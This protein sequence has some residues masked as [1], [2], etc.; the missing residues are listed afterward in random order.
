MKKML[1][2]TLVFVLAISCCFAVA[3]TATAETMGMAVHTVVAKAEN[4][5]TDDGKTTD[6]KYSLETAVCAVVL[7]DE[8]KIT[9]IRF[10]LTISDLGVNA[11]GAVLTEAGTEMKSKMDLKEAYGMGQYAPAG[12]WY[13]QVQALERYC[14]GKTVAEVLST[15][16]TASGVLDVEDLKTSCT[17]GVN[18]LLKA[19]ELAAANAR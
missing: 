17:I 1:G 8:G 6:G 4:A 3:A 7:D 14:I 16:T 10:D 19:L 5:Y 13:V 2:L 9:N 11:Q 12:E 18:N 15:P